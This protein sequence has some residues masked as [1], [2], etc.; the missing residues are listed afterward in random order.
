MGKQWANDFKQWAN[1]FKQ[2]PNIPKVGKKKKTPD[3]PLSKVGK[4]K[5]SA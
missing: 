5:V 2:C 4:D 1:E 3:E